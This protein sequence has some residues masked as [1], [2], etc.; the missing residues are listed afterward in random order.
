L[1]GLHFVALEPGFELAGRRAA[2]AVFFVTVVTRFCVSG[3]N[4]RIATRGSAT[5]TWCAGRLGTT[6]GGTAIAEVVVLII[7]TLAA[8]GDP[9]SAH[10]LLTGLSRS[11]TEVPVF[12]RARRRT[13]IPTRHVAVVA[14]LAAHDLTIAAH[15]RAPNAGSRAGVSDLH[16][17]Q[18]GAA[19]AGYGVGVVTLFCTD[20][21][22]VPA[23][24]NILAGLTRC[25]TR[26]ATFD[27]ARVGTAIPSHDV[28][29]VA[30]FRRRDEGVATD[31]HPK[32][33]GAI[34][35]THPIVFDRAGSRTAIARF[36][37]AVITALGF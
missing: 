17:A 1:R 7:T 15:W 21:L 8:V 26:K 27:L 35:G 2:I 4:Q 3:E 23:N 13:A 22:T 24:L 20:H 25:R 11:C 37:V 6:T 28:S 19:I 14:V 9:I 31:V 10:R 30:G 32:T 18:V 29:V 12:A 5:E 34:C 36:G 16:H 33:R